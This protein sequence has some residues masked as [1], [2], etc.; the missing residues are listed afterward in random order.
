MKPVSLADI[1]Y[2]HAIGLIQLRKEAIDAGHIQR[3]TPAVLADSYP[4]R[5]A[6]NELLK[7]GSV[8]KRAEGPGFMQN[9][10]DGWDGLKGGVG[11][12]WDGLKGGVKSTWNDPA[13][14][15][16][17]IGGGLGMAAGAG[18]TLMDDEDDS[19]IRNMLMGGTGGAALGGGLGLMANQS[20]RDK[21]Q[22]AIEEQ[23]EGWPPSTP[24]DTPEQKVEAEVDQLVEY[25]DPTR[26]GELGDEANSLTPEGIKVLGEAASIYGGGKL[27]S[28]MLPSSSLDPAK[29]LKNVPEADMS[30]E[31]VGELEG[32]NPTPPSKIKKPNRSMGFGSPSPASVSS[33]ASPTAEALAAAKKDPELVR[34]FVE[35]MSDDELRKVLQQNGIA[36]N[37]LGNLEA[38]A[39]RLS[40]L[41][42][43]AASEQAL[44]N[45]RLGHVT[46]EA[47][48]KLKALVKNVAPE[49]LGGG[50]GWKV[51]PRGRAGL[52]A[53]LGG[54]L[55]YGG[56]R[57]TDWASGASNASRE[58]SRKI[59]QGLHDRRQDLREQFRKGGK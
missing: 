29:W 47:F 30:W 19:Y 27:T 44:K 32:I 51:L 39:S 49:F 59:L 25:P 48:P 2:D 17:I 24:T 58:N 10:R 15:A 6:G 9:L 23:T 28:R 18:K 50:K 26:E 53:A 8:E 37:A 13:G 16:A 21:V 52:A 31:R 57:L 22:K 4:M 34:K 1:T 54:G 11:D 20:S 5:D 38:A 33:P 3:M 56:H 41:A 42:P 43:G 12:G 46:A 36:P 35:G 14:K 40:K 7:S 55:Y 45:N